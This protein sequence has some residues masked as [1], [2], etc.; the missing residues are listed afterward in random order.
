M[1]RFTTIITSCSA[2][3][4]MQFVRQAAELGYNQ[5][6]FQSPRKKPVKRLCLSLASLLLLSLAACS[7]ASA[8]PAATP[9]PLVLKGRQVFNLRCATCHGLEPG[10]V[11]VGP[12][13]A[14]VATTAGTRMPGYDARAYL[15]L[16]ILRPEAYIVE[17]YT[18]VMPRNF[19]KELTSEELD[20]LIAFLLSLK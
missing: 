14:G 18:D 7:R 9:D 16:S 17:G 8:A 13:L 15:E 6:G 3:F 1:D 4:N 11:I 5:V 10:T 2:A 20:E 19:P 12:S